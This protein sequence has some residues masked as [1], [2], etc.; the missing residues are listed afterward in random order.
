[1]SAPM[2]FFTPQDIEALEEWLETEEHIFH[3]CGFSEGQSCCLED[4]VEELRRGFTQ[5]SFRGRNTQS[6][7]QVN[8]ATR[9]DN[10]PESSKDKH[11]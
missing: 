8:G 6:V 4:A 7:V 3:C 9:A 10:T 1:M 5:D 2:P 11:E